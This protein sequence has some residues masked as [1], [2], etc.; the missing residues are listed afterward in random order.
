MAILLTGGAGFIGSHT[1]VCLMQAGYDVVLANIVADV[2]I[3]LAPH[4]PQFLKP[5]GIFICSG[6]LDVR[7]HEVH[8]ALKRAGLHILSTDAQE[9][10][11]RV[12]AIWEG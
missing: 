10:W 9:D 1:A 7:L 5:G 4:V 2:I 12:A 3:P 8:A 6:I 11:R